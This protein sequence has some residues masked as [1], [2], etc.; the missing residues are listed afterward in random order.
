MGVTQSFRLQRIEYW[1]PAA[2]REGFG[3]NYGNAIM[4]MSAAAPDTSSLRT[5]ISL[6]EIFIAAD[7][8]VFLQ[9]MTCRESSR[10][11]GNAA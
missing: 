9:V 6:N 7:N 8:T 1:P 5:S 2:L 10:H 3:G 4:T 11:H